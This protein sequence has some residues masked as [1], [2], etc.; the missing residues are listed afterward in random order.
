MASQPTPL[1]TPAN[2]T[3]AY[4]LRYHF[5]WHTHGR[6]PL[7]A[8]VAAKDVLRRALA[9][10]ATERGYHIIEQDIGPCVLR[11]LLSLLP[12]HSPAEATRVIK[13]NLAAAARRELSLPNIWS[14]GAFLRSVGSATDDVVQ[15]YVSDQLKHH[16]AA[17]LDNPRW[18]ADAQYHADGDPTALREGAHGVFE[19]NVHVVFVVERRVDFLD[20]HVAAELVGY[21]RRVC[22]K[23]QWTPWDIGVVRD[24][25]H[26]FLGLRPADC[27]RD[28]ALS[29][30][31]NA[32]YFLE[33]RYA[34]ALRDL[35]LHGVWRPG[36]YVGTV[37]AATTAQVKAFLGPAVG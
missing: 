20:E 23:H 25:A 8:S 33:R 16:Q 9:E 34:G 37:G 14:R 11:A 18:G 1:F 13:G 3:P 5:G 36:Y 32:A 4:Q 31:A 12:E 17:P 29:L 24:H 21:W 27:P 7:F 2:T 26:L 28:V 19:C 22:S 6:R 15:R 10:V 30:M 35:S